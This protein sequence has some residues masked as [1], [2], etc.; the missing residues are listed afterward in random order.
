MM[1]KEGS[2]TQNGTYWMTPF[3][4]NARK[5]TPVSRDRKMSSCLGMG[6]GDKEG[7]GKD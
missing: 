5:H 3:I 1:L 4:R 7:D 6:K 2:Q